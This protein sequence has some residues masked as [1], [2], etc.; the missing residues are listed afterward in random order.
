MVGE[1]CRAR[2]VVLGAE[3]GGRWSQETAEGS[4]C[5][6]FQKNSKSTRSERSSHDG[7]GCEVVLIV[8]VVICGEACLSGLVFF[9][10]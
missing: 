2:L 5:A 6:I 4:R 9:H 7:R 3:V 8:H 1:G 10:F